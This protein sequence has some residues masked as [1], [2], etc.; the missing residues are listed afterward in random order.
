M[1]GENE[2]KSYF[3]AKTLLRYHIIFSTKYR[4]KCLNSIR[5]IIFNA[6]KHA[7]KNSRFE[8]LTMEID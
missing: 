7:E 4:Y 6:F 3:H 2:Y 5:D 1:S 8:I